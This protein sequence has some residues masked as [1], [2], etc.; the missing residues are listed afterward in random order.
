M[1]PPINQ[2]PGIVG[3]LRNLLKTMFFA[4]TV[5]WAV[6]SL[7]GCDIFRQEEA[8]TPTQPTEAIP[9][10]PPEFDP[11]ILVNTFNSTLSLT[12]SPEKISLN[13]CGGLRDSTLTQNVSRSFIA[14]VQ[15]EVSDQLAGEFGAGIEIVEAK[16]RNEIGA[17]LGV[18]FG[19]Q[20]SRSSEVVANVPPGHKTITTVQYQEHWTKG[21]VEILRPDGSQIDVLPFAALDSLAFEQQQVVAVRCADNEIVLPHT[22]APTEMPSVTPELAAT[23]IS[24]PTPT[25]AP[26]EIPQPPTLTPVSHVTTGAAQIIVEGV[27]A[28]PDSLTNS[29]LRERAA[30]QAAEVDA[31]RK[32]VEWADGAEIESVT[33][34]EQGT[35]IIDTIRSYV[36]AEVPASTI[37]SKKFDPVTG[38]AWVTLE[39]RVTNGSSR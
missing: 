31:K 29:A 17:K 11:T 39:V 16:I 27:G 28:A 9:N 10:P 37:I 21:E 36:K 30:Y 33:I 25:D 38:T 34:V 23:A 4:A 20:L 18:R 32:L 2:P 5:L 13:N 15:L 14:E 35:L 19:T 1:S 6:I 24:T 26:A 12:G 7:S 3:N 22:F 8:P